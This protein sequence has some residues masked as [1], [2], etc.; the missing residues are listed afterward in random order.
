M[1]LVYSVP[2]MSCGH[3]VKAITTGVQAVPGVSD[4]AIELETKTVTVTLAGA[5]DDRAGHGRRRGNR[6]R[7]GRND[8]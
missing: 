8:Q 7:R 4:V 1:T 2:G 3:C 5:A 6:R